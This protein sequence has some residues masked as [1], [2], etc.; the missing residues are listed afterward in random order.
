MRIISV[1][2]IDPKR[3][4]RIRTGQHRKF[5]LGLARMTPQQKLARAC[6]LSDQTKAGLKQAIRDRFPE[7]SEAE[8]HVLFLER[9]DRCRKRNSLRRS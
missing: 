8:V 3:Q 6:A 9:L 4:L 2:M 5:L 7:K 1:D